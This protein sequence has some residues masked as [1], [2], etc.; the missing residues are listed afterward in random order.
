MQDLKIFPKLLNEKN[1]KAAGEDQIVIEAIKAGKFTIL[2]TLALLYNICFL[3]G[4]TPFKWDKAV[5]IIFHI[6]YIT[7]KTMINKNTQQIAIYF[8]V[9]Y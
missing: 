9:D 5:I 3:E 7:V 4:V 1:N 8:F 2:K 6:I